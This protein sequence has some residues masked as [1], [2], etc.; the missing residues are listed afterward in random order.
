M[1]SRIILSHSPASLLINDKN[2]EIEAL[3]LNTTAQWV[4][5]N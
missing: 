5:K 3:S 2:E 4:S 1:Q